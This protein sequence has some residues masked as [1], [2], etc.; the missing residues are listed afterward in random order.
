MILL[1]NLI[2]ATLFIIY[3]ETMYFNNFKHVRYRDKIC[4]EA[5]QKILVTHAT[6]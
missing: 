2:F 5:K 3:Y 4:F 1:Y 6:V